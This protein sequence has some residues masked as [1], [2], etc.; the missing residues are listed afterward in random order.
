MYHSDSENVEFRARL[1]LAGGH[2]GTTYRVF[3]K[4]V[5]PNPTS[6]WLRTSDACMKY[7]DRAVLTIVSTLSSRAAVGNTI[8]ADLHIYIH[9]II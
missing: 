6:E 5:T 9:A 8:V 7:T 1:V 4:K 2:A 3:R